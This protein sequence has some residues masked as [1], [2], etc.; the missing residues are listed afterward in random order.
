M[1]LFLSQSAL[2]AV[3]STGAFRAIEYDLPESPVE[4]MVC[5]GVVSLLLILGVRVYLR[6]TAELN[7][8][9]RYFLLLLRLSVL[10]GLVAV[11]LNPQERTQKLA[12]RPSQVAVLIDRSLSMKFPENQVGPNDSAEES[13]DASTAD[14]SRTRADA[15]AEL[16]GKSGML[17]ELRKNHAVSVY[18][19]DFAL[20]GP[21]AALRSQDAR[22]VVK[23]AATS[24]G[25][26]ATSLEETVD[27][28]QIVDPVGLETRLGESLLEL[29]RS[30]SG[31]SLSGIVVITDGASN[32]GIDPDKAVEAAKELKARL[33]T[34]GVGSTRQPVNIQIASVQAPSDVHV[35]DAFE[36]SAFVQAQ[37]LAG[38]NAIVELLGRPENSEGD[39]SKLGTKEIVLADDGLPVRV[40]FEQLENVAG[41]WEY[42]VRV[43]SDQKIVELSEGDN[44]RRKSISV[45]DRKTRVL[46]IAGGPMRD[47]QFVRNMLYRHS[48]IQTDVWLQTA[49]A[50]GAVSQEANKILTSFPES[51][52]ELFDYDVIVGFD[53]DWNRL[54]PEQVNLV[55]EWVFAQAGGLVVVAGDVYSASVA[56][57]ARLEKI[58]ELY[59]VVLNRFVTD[60]AASRAVIQSWPFEFTR[61]G[62]EA[63]FLQITDEQVS[64]AEVWKEFQGVYSAY[65]TSG[66]KAGATVY[67]YFS[68]PRT[69]S[70]SGLPV[71]LAS[72]YYGAGRV[73]YLGSP[74]M[75][76][77]RSID[78]VYYDRFW[79]KSI[80]EAGQARLKRGNNRGTLL[81]ERNQFVLG[82]TVRVRA[83]LTDP[84]FNPLVA[85]SVLAEIFDPDGRPMFPPV[86]LQRDSN[87]AG[88][89]VGSFRVSSPGVWRIDIPIPQSGD[90]LSEK[91]DVILPNLE[92]DNAR[93]NAQLLRLIAEDTGGTYFPL[94]EAAAEVP[95][96][97]PDRG[98]EFQIDQQLKTLWDRE[99]LMYL[100]IGLLSVEWLTRKLLKLA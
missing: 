74:E 10:A 13:E 19:F 12:Y 28:N 21:H 46:V 97:L 47:Y 79:T 33:I 87:R 37:G 83:Q 62:R 4:W 35:G 3:E 90:Q 34:V 68:D 99:W 64:S 18:S 56:S 76:R 6:D 29:I 36:I 11:A 31:N 70:A 61:E 69:Q 67:A 16:L 20:N 25:G 39:A 73:I 100:L 43:R 14:E 22:A 32:S 82:Q 2:L 98:E 63:G 58:R 93:Q 84:Q 57:D 51:K 23:S 52:E 41:V 72:Q 75:W 44:E 55:S 7:R 60:S 66:A 5:L 77:M 88:Q 42:F 81:L 92:T 53:P 15:V 94:D 71:L 17:E 8:F 80:R 59:P 49:D 54:S 40:S 95:K 24:A 9:W 30:I 85:D 1:T 89:F 50:A 38:Q 91:I 65:P 86:R 78:E 96:R 45:V 48:A 27:W 26:D